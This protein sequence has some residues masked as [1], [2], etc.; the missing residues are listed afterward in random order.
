MAYVANQQRQTFNEIVRGSFSIS[1]A[2]FQVNK[3]NR[4]G[5]QY[6][7]SLFKIQANW[8]SGSLLVNSELYVNQ[9]I[10]DNAGSPQFDYLPRGK[11][12]PDY[13]DFPIYDEILPPQNRNRVK[14]SHLLSGDNAFIYDNFKISFGNIITDPQDPDYYLVDVYVFTPP[15][16][17]GTLIADSYCYILNTI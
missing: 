5:G 2:T 9:T 10:Y 1:I 13:D 17:D 15:Y 8:A 16:E 6:P 12:F 4:G 7:Y 3:Y 11:T 14:Y